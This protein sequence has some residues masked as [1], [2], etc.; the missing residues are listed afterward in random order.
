[1][2]TFVYRESVVT[3][4]A[5]IKTTTVPMINNDHIM[6]SWLVMGFDTWNYRII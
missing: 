1:M 5:V 3:L 6:N 4:K 2:S